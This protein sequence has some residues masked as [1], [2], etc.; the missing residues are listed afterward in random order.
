VPLDRVAP[1][2]AAQLAAIDDR[3]V[4]KRHEPVITA[5]LPA[6]GE[7]GPRVE[8]AGEPG[9]PFL[10]CNANGYLGMATRHELC[11]AAERATEA[12]GVGP[13]AVRFISGTHTPHVALEARL[14][15]F[16]GRECAV[17][18][19]SA[20]AAMVGLLPV[21][22]TPTTAVVSD[23]LNHNCI[24]NAARLAQPAQRL[25]YRHL[26]MGHL[27]DMLH[28]VP[29]TVT[30]VVVVT[31]GVFS[32]RGD[33]AP[34]QVLGEVIGRH[35]A[36][37]DDGVISVVDDS[38]GV[39]ALGAT[40]RGTEEA[41]AGRADVFVATLGK[42]LGA[43]GGY[44]CGPAALCDLL[45]ETAATYVFSN[46]IGPGDAAAALT[47]L[48]L[49]DGPVGRE[50]LARVRA[51]AAQLRAGIVALGYETIAGEHP[52]VP[53]V[54][55][56]GDRNRA[57]AAHLRANGVLATALSYPVVPRGDDE[58]RFQVSA[59]HTTSDVAELLGVLASFPDRG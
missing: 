55:R 25:V 16:H 45:R 31:D 2:L 5:V 19:G 49:L 40:G 48:D 30:R 54:T 46:P 52:V 58:I 59:E 24:I 44:V 38:H 8:L 32:M 29:P 6:R 15:A 28:A 11:A 53:L 7:L 34:L 22:V 26:D 35:H 12:F 21:L 14:A 4:A 33:H 9:R 23:E 27:D 43:N 51:R 39:G 1:A 57:L 10:R 18:F 56:D 41:S 13:Q 47:A 42:A 17:V 37:F 20:Y 50:L 3:G 36:R